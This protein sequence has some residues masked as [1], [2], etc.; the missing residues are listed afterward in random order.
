MEEIDWTK[1]VKEYNRWWNGL[2]P[3]QKAEAYWKMGDLF[4]SKEA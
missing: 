2:T 1:Y 4:A 3:P